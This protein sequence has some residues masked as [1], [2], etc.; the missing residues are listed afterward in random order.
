MNVTGVLSLMATLL[1]VLNVATAPAETRLNVLTEEGPPFNYSTPQGAEG[2]SV[3]IVREIMRRT[4]TESEIR[5]QPWARAFDTA[6]KEP[7]TVLF[8]TTRTAERENLFHWVGPI[9]ENTWAL[10]ARAESSLRIESPDDARK[11][12]GISAYRAD[13]R[14]QYLLDQGFMNIRSVSDFESSVRM[15]LEGR[16]PVVIAD[17]VGL[18]HLLRRLDIPENSITALYEIKRFGLYIALSLN[19]DQEIVQAWQKAFS[20]MV[21]DGTFDGIYQKWLPPGERP[22]FNDSCNSE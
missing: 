21:R 18:K 16:V 11:L 6:L 19:T 3:D 10:Y 7:N 20:D 4:N 5:I 2:F 17:D 1:L 8:T 9:M 15:M 12:S 14:E 22:D 13:V